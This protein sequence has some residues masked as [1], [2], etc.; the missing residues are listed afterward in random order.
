[1]AG[2]LYPVLLQTCQ[3]CSEYLS[4]LLS[5]C[6][7]RRG[8][9][10]SGNPPEVLTFFASCSFFR[11]YPVF[12]FFRCFAFFPGTSTSTINTTGVRYVFGFPFRVHK[13]SFLI[14]FLFY[15]LSFFSFVF[16][17]QV[18]REDKGDNARRHHNQA[19]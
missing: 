14:F 2:V 10:L 7:C 3:T 4:A 13:N 12:S 16:S 6:N 1:M 18:A 15:F 19:Q 9:S 11:F 5:L 17:L 8:N